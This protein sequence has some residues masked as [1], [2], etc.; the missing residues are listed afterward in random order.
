M[1]H[2]DGKHSYTHKQHDGRVKDTPNTQNTRKT[3]KGGFLMS[4]R[5]GYTF[6]PWTLDNHE[7]VVVTCGLK[8]EG[9]RKGWEGTKK[10]EKEKC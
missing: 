7:K 3:N 8:T 10:K 1:A 6:N 9:R 2:T 4:H 5:K